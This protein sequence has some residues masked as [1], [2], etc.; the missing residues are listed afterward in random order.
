MMMMDMTL[1]T[2]TIEQFRDRVGHAFIILIR[3]ATMLAD[4][5]NRDQTSHVRT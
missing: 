1:D 4:T 3:K 5:R 2:L